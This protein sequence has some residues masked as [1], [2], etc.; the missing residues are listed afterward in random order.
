MIKKIQNK[1]KSYDQLLNQ[2][3]CT[4]VH[5]ARKSMHIWIWLCDENVK[6]VSVYKSYTMV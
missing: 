3:L 2:K 4:K 6:N 5:Y 1:P